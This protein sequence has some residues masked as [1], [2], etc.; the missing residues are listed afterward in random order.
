MTAKVLT[1][2]QEAFAAGVARGLSASD[3]YRAAYPNKMSGKTLTEAASRLGTNSNV[4]A[5]VAELRAPVA[6]AAQ[7][8][9]LV[10]ANRTLF[11]NAKIAF[12]DVRKL[13]DKDTGQMLQPHQWSDEMAG[14]VSSIKVRELFGEGKD[15]VGAIGTI[16]EVKLWDK[17]AALDRLDKRFGAYALDNKQKNDAL[18]EVS[19]DILKMMEQRIVG[20]AQPELDRRPTAGGSGRPSRKGT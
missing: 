4:V 3:A 1:A 11:E 16:T 18:D 7:E 6:V 10:D 20:L 17:G 8:T 5:R 12:S 2:K 15:G 9:V 19:R 13:F 14:A